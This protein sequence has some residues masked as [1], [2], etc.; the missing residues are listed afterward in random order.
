VFLDENGW[1]LDEELDVDA[2]ENLVMNVA[3]SQWDRDQTTKGLR[4]LLEQ[5]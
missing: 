5:E 1:L 2:W 3:S 4:S